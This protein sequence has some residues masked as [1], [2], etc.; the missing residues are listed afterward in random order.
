MG[1]AMGLAQKS[2]RNFTTPSVAQIR[3]LVPIYTLDTERQ[4]ELA[5][6]TRC[7]NYPAGSKLFSIGEQHDYIFYLLRGAIE[8]YNPDE[9]Y[10]LIADTEQAL[11]PIDPHRPHQYN[12]I[13]A[14]DAEVAVIDR[15]LLDILLTWNP[16]SNYDVEEINTTSFDPDNWMA[17]IL[18]SPVFQ[19]IPPIKIQAMFQ[20]AESI[21]VR[22]HEL[23]FLQGDA[24]DYFYLIQQGNCTVLRSKNKQ[25]TI[26]AE[27]SAG[28]SF[29]EEALLSN[30]PRN[31]T[32]IMKTDGVLLRL[33]KD[34]FEE[35]LKQPVVETIGFEQAEQ[36]YIRNPIWLDVRQPE[37][38]YESAIEES[39]NIPLYRVRETLSE[40]PRDR[41][42]IVYC[43]NAHRSSCAVYL[44]NAYGFE[45][46]VLE[47][48]LQSQT[49]DVD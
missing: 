48:G 20:K 39:I 38:H 2:T 5:K 22:E 12:A 18:Q 8:I 11:M 41:P 10:T 13:F 31:A 46:Y 29:G 27:L 19:R 32:V 30:D 40:L 28:Q 3:D 35:L 42:Y 15:N 21:S 25:D 43:D 14:S 26:V 33:A 36:M 16:F 17:S 6:H 47:N 4:Q 45:A 49:K 1:K 9:R 37:E 7:F 34:D 44:L 24:G 23:I